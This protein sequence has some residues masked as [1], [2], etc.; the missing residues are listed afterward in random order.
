[1]GLVLGLLVLGVVGWHAANPFVER[2]IKGEL[3]AQLSRA[4]GRPVTA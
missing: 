3:L 4:I 1:M 2:R